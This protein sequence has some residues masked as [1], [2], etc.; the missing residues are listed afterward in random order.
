MVLAWVKSITH[1]YD[2]ETIEYPKLACLAKLKQRLEA[3]QRGDYPDVH[4]WMR[5]VCRYAADAR[6]EQHL[7]LPLPCGGP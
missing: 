3:I 4:N 7:T 5:A 1:G 6:T 2:G